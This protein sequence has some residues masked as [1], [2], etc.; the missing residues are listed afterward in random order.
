MMERHHGEC[1]HNLAQ[2]QCHYFQTV[3]SQIYV[4]WVEALEQNLCDLDQMW[5]K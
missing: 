2:D 3:L 1:V 4:I 5:L